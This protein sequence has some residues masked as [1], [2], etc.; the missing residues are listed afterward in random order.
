MDKIDRAVVKSQARFMLKGKFFY[1]FII[2]FIVLLLTGSLSSIATVDLPKISNEDSYSSGDNSDYGNYGNFGDFDDSDNPIENFSF[3]SYQEEVKPESVSLDLRGV[4][5]NISFT[6]NITGVLGIVF[7]PLAVTLA[8][9]YLNFIRRRPDEAF[10]ISDELGFLFK[11]TFD[12]TY[13]KKLVLGILRSLIIFAL[14]ILFIVPGVIYY[15]KSYFA[16]QLLDEYPDL[17]PSEAIKLSGKITKG[18]KTELFVLDL[19]FIGWYLLGIITLGIG[20]I[21]VLPYYMTTQ[22]LYYENFRLRALAC[23]KVTEDDFLS[24]QQRFAKYN[25]PF[26]YNG[27]N[28]ANQYG[29]NNS[30]GYNPNNRYGSYNQNNPYNPYYQYN[31]NNQYNQNAAGAA[32][33]NV[34]YTPGSETQPQNAEQPPEQTQQSTQPQ[35]TETPYGSSVDYGNTVDNPAENPDEDV[36]SSPDVTNNGTD[37]ADNDNPFSVPPS[38]EQNQQDNQ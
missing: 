26:G 30:Y 17:K 12:G 23:N 3:Q 5:D 19:S 9:I 1:L 34:Y 15:Y 22:A 2:T 14:A 10:H 25:Q 35:Q 4:T 11:H 21:Y 6:G 38:D 8:Q 37:S 20:M 7:T 32:D 27:Y 24:E 31:Q 28:N 13:V 36:K 29:Q 33:G 16:Y 18:N